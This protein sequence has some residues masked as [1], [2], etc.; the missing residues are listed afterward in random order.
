MFLFMCALEK[1]K[2]TSHATAW[3]DFVVVETKL[4]GQFNSPLIYKI[5][6]PNSNTTMILNT[7]I[8]VVCGHLGVDLRAHLSVR[9]TIK[10][11]AVQ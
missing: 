10:H 7:Y 2:L 6:L 5:D 8:W 3:R 11:Y 4:C 1:Q 9:V